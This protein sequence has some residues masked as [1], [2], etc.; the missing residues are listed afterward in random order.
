MV[1]FV[2]GTSSTLF[3]AALTT[4]TTAN[5]SSIIVDAIQSILSDISQQDN[6]VA[7]Y[8]NAFAGWN[9]DTNPVCLR[10]IRLDR[11]V[12]TFRSLTSLVLLW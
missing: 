6:D 10:S 8:P 12:L 1:R 11:E 3:S 9:P 2:A 4:L 5:A 7:Q